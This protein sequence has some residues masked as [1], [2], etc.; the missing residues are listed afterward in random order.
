MPEWLTGLLSWL[1]SPGWAALFGAVLGSTATHM[2]HVWRERRQH[3]RELEGLLRLIEKEIHFNQLSRLPALAVRQ[4]GDLHPRPGGRPLVGRP[5]VMEAWQ[6][7]RVRIAQ[8]LL[9]SKNFGELTTYYRDLQELNDLLD[10]HASP[11]ERG[12]LK[13]RVIE[14]T[15]KGVAV[16][17]WIEGNYLKEEHR[18]WWQRWFGP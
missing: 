16:R 9:N 8:L 15:N 7:A 13:R 4:G 2:W 14:L 5:L 10:E 3:A 18:P 17:Q 6:L 12:D 11:I 1:V